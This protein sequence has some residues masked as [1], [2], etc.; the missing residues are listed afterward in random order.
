MFLRYMFLFLAKFG[1]PRNNFTNF[2]LHDM[3]YMICFLKNMVGGHFRRHMSNSGRS[4]VGTTSNRTTNRQARLSTS[5]NLSTV[6]KVTLK[7][8]KISKKTH[9]AVP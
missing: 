4:S 3:T 5:A 1:P 6:N 2:L 7:Y 9:E 8:T